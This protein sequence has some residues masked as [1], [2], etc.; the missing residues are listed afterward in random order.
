VPFSL[1]LVK[2]EMHSAPNDNRT[3]LRGMSAQTIKRPI[4]IIRRRIP[5]S[6]QDFRDLWSCST[7]Y[8][9]AS[10]NKVGCS[11]KIS[12]ARSPSAVP[13]EAIIAF[14]AFRSQ[15]SESRD[16][17]S[18]LGRLWKSWRLGLRNFQ[19]PSTRRRQC[20]EAL[21]LFRVINQEARATET[22]VV[23]INDC[24]GNSGTDEVVTV[25][26]V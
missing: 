10:T 26:K 2:S 14:R 8:E 12:A 5:I 3:E 21:V 4:Y 16:R 20:W 19:V 1:G 25:L 17:R 13:Q 18:L 7:R 6:C 24:A 22:A 15:R 23:T 11:Q 9:Q